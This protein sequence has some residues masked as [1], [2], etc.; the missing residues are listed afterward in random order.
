MLL[1]DFF[2]R[3]SRLIILNI[4]HVIIRAIAGSSLFRAEPHQTAPN[5][6]AYE[7]ALARQ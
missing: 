5:A 2:E 4:T 3:I 6:G 1:N 7:K